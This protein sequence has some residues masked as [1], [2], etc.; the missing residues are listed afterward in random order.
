MQLKEVDTATSRAD[1]QLDEHLGQ[2]PHHFFFRR[3][4]ARLGIEE[5]MLLGEV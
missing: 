5:S 1:V 4:L 3:A 2:A